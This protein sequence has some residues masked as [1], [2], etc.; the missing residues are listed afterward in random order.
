MTGVLIAVL[1]ASTGVVGAYLV[2]A[3]VAVDSQQT[4]QDPSPG[5]GQ[6]LPST[7]ASIPTAVPSGG[8]GV[9]P[10][11]GTSSSPGG[12]VGVA[13]ARPADALSGW[14]LP[15]ATRL[16][17]PKIAL[18][19]Y[20]YAE[21]VLGQNNPGCRLSWTTLAAIG[22]VE[23]NHGRF[24]NGTL[25]SKGVSSP[26]IIGPALD[27]K[28]G[29]A[30]VPDTDDAVLDHDA[31]WDHAVGPMQFI[32]STWATQEVDADNDGERNPNDID[33]AAL[34]AANYLCGNGR[35]LS[36]PQGWW[37]AIAAYNVPQ[38]YGEAVFA[39]ANSYGSLSRG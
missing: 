8:P 4:G 37:A 21:L 36:T 32:P 3:T 35:D 14:A 20:G 11:P 5:A 10:W 6:D 38:S 12:P 26:P 33:D 17:I 23:S 30:S 27:G 2:P 34:A 18:E 7:S 25:D 22:K 16:D 15:M 19:A 29:R 31:V 1:V 9:G 24:N 13:A 39:A 28:D